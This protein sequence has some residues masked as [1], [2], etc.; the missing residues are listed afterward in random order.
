M[1]DGKLIHI[2][3]GYFLSNSPRSLNFESAPFKLTQEF[4]DVLGGLSSDL[5]HYYK[6]K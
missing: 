4:V 6:V 3:F 2:D 1:K 5:Y